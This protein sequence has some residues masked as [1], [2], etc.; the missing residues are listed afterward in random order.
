MGGLVSDENTSGNTKVPLLGDIP[1]LGLAFRKDTK[2]RNRQNLIVF[3]T[4]TIVKDTDFQ[5]A[6]SKFLQST[7]KESAT[8][9]VSPWNS[10]KP[11]DWTK[12]FGKKS[13]PD[14]Q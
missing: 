2:E 13:A 14:E 10:G 1:F 11:Y 6:Q 5:A 4:P 8:E 9:D 7:G 3:I 12:P